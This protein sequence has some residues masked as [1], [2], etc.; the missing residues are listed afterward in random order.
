MEQ[1]PFWET[2]RSSANRISR[3]LWNPKF[4]YRIHKCPPTVPTLNLLDPVHAP[5]SHFLKILLNIILQSRPGSSKWPLSLRFSYQNPVCTSS[6]PIRATCPAHLILVDLIT[7]TVFGEQYRSL[8]S[9]LCNFLHSRVALSLLG[10][11]I[12]LSTLFSNTLTCSLHSTF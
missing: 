7:Q 5:T 1:S 12:L 6:L 3:I 8:I 4:H 2:N 10:P 9:S 11:N